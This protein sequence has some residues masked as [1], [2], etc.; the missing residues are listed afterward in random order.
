MMIT[1][2]C[3]MRMN[4]WELTDYYDLNDFDRDGYGNAEDAFPT[5]ETEWLDSDGD[6]I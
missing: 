6:G 1:M 5:D 3:R 4:F 2:V